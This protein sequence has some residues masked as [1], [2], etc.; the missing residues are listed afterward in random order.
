M[1]RND[2]LYNPDLYPWAMNP[3]EAVLTDAGPF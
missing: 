2:Q 1:E 3:L